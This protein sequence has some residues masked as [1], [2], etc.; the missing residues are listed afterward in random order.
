MND[1]HQITKTLVRSGAG[2][3]FESRIGC[4]GDDNDGDDDDRICRC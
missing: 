1:D 4:D 3:R 2:C